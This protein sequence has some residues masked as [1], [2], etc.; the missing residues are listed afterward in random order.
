[1]RS[2]LLILCVACGSFDHV[3]D[4]SGVASLDES[5]FKCQI[6]PML[7][8]DCSY[9]ACHGEATFPLRIYSVGKLRLGVSTD[10]T[11]RTL[12]LTPDEEHANFL[13]ASGFAWNGVA[14]FD[15]LLI[16]KP[17]PTAEG[18]YEHKGGAI[19]AGGDDRRVDHLS[20]W[21]SSAPGFTCASP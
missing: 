13:S 12:P 1:L 21:L 3:P 8:R 14:P 20:Q 10:Q 7:I 5:I 4:P 11:S 18:G 19:Y 17:L 6:E 2:L 16:R 15:N 9:I